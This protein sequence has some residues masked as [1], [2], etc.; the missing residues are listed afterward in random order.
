MASPPTVAR[1]LWSDAAVQEAVSKALL[2]PFVMALG[3]GQLPK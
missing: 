1:R 3:A 2:H